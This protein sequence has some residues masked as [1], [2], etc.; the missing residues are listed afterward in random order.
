[1]ATLMGCNSGEGE[2]D[3]ADTTWM[4]FNKSVEGPTTFTLYVNADGT[5]LS[6]V[7]TLPLV[8]L[9]DGLTGL[10]A[11]PRLVGNLEDQE[12]ETLRVLL[13]AEQQ[14]VY[15]QD[16]CP[17]EAGCGS[18]TTYRLVVRPGFDG[19]TMAANF[20]DDV[21]SPGTRA[22][23][24]GIVSIMKRT[25]EDGVPFNESDEARANERDWPTP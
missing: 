22:M 19:P 10:S 23:I 9:G 3:P 7:G 15:Q 21:T 13:G 4:I 11:G 1:M 5:F 8:N 18:G 14:Q 24:E 20:A 25:F 16:A 17:A 2:T 6:S 12:V